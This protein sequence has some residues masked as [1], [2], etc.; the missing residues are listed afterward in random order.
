M[1][2]ITSVEEKPP[3]EHEIKGQKL[4]HWL[5]ENLSRDF[6]YRSESIELIKTITDST[7]PIRGLLEKGITSVDIYNRYS[8]QKQE[9][10][11]FPI[12]AG[13]NA[14]GEQQIHEDAL[15]HSIILKSILDTKIPLAFVASEEAEPVLGSNRDGIGIT[16]DPVDGSSNVV[17][18]RTVGTIVGMW[19]KGKII[20]SF[21]V[22]YGIY[23]NLVLAIDGKVAEFILEPRAYSINYFHFTFERY[24]K[25]PN[26]ASKGIRCIGGDLL[27]FSPKV[28]EYLSALTSAS[29][30]DRYS[31]S[32][33]GDMHAIFYYGGVYGYFPCPKGKIRLYY[34]WLPLALI[35][36]TL[37]GE[38]F[39]V[40]DGIGPYKY[41]RME[42]QKGLNTESLQDIHRTVCGGLVGS[43]EAVVMFQKIS[44]TNKNSTRI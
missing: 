41:G 27:K 35:C 19:Q 22:L 25:M 39:R 12:E 37:G 44:E 18:N 29:F 1:N 28:I 8:F 43:R 21:Y 26:P 4:S 17:V 2:V 15:T 38:F 7:K 16:I 36:K 10:I 5:E 24:L 32:F 31:G 33:V 11:T 20:A 13:K 34:E 14:Y 42:D 3:A 9:N 23:T 40:E 30:K 6:P